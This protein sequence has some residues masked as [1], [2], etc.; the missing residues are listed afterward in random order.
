MKRAARIAALLSLTAVWLVGADDS[1]IAKAGGA[2]T[3]DASGHITRVDL[4]SSWVTDVDLAQLAAIPTLQS[5]DLS[6]TRITDHGMQ[7]L[8][9]A[10]NI[11]DLN[12]RYAELVTDEGV[13][14]IKD[15]KHLKRINLRGTHITDTTLEHLAGIETLESIDVGFAQITDVG[16]DRLAG[17]PHLK[18]LTLGGNKLTDVGL[19]PLRHLQ[20]LTYLDIGGVQ[21]TD[22]GLWSINLGDRGIETIATLRELRE[23]RLAGTAVS[24]ASIEKLDTLNKLERIELQ[25]CKRI[26]DDAAPAMAAL[27]ALQI[28]DLKGTAFTEAGVRDLK[29][30]RPNAQAL[31]GPIPSRAGVR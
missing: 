10:P 3:R 6:L 8:K 12:L 9:T 18:E 2:V 17:L 13:A 5:L 30:A 11:T 14:A 31:Y 7:Q 15:W 21:R 28:A 20:T 23:L 24:A 29:A 22:S 26:G 16:P 19:Q 1:W 4:H 27:P 25:G